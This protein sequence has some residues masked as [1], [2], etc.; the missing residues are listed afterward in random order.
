VF[1]AMWN[2]RKPMDWVVWTGANPS[3]ALLHR[4]DLQRSQATQ[5]AV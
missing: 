1:D 3:D 2:S 5:D 4:E